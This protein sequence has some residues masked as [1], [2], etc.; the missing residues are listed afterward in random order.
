MGF[1]D[2]LQHVGTGGCTTN[3]NTRN[4]Q[5]TKQRSEDVRLKT[6]QPPH[7]TANKTV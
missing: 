2:E 3:W 4:D 5:Q 1:A 6:L 7:R